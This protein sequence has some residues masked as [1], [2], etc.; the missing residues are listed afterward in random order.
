[1]IFFSP[2]FAL[3]HYVS[4]NEL[5][6][7]HLV[8]KNIILGSSDHSFAGNV[9]NQQHLCGPDET[10]ALHWKKQQIELSR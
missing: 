6:N 1:M 7:S 10:G 4:P 2:H 8:D 3:Y 9:S 5:V